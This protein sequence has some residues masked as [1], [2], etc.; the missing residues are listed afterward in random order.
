MPIHG[1]PGGVITANPTEPSQTSASGVWTTEQQLINQSAGR[2][3]PPYYLI[4]RSLRF[5]FADSTYLNRTPGS[6]GNLRIWTLS[7]WVKLCQQTNDDGIIFSAGTG[8]SARSQCY[9]ALSTGRLYFTSFVSA[10]AYGAFTNAQ[11]R[12]PSAWYHVV[13]SV[14]TTQTTAANRVIFY[15][16]GVAQSMNTS[17]GGG[18]IPQNSDTYVNAANGHC[19]G[20]NPPYSVGGYPTIYLTEQYLIDGQALTPSSFGLNDPETGVW[21]PKRYTGTYGTNGF[22]LNFSDNSGTT[23]TTLGKDS[24]GNGNNWTPN[25]FSVTAGA[26]NDSMVDSPTAY[27]TDTGVGGEVRGNYATVSP[28]GYRTTTPTP[29]ISNGNLDVVCPSGSLSSIGTSTFGVSSGKWYWEVT[30][31][32]TAYGNTGIVLTPF[33]MAASSSLDLGGLSNEYVYVNSGSKFNNNSSSSYGASW[34]NGDVIGVALDLDAGT[35]VFYKNGSSQGTAFSSLPSGIYLV[36]GYDSFNGS[37]F[38]FNFGQRAFAYTAPSGFKALCTQ[39]LPTPTIGA[40]S[41]TQANDYFNVVLWTGNGST[42]NITGVGFQP[43]FVWA[44]KRSGAESHGLYD[45]VRGASNRLVSNTTAAAVTDAGVS[46]FLSDGFSISGAD[47][48]VTNDNGSTYVGWN[49]KANGAGSSNTAGTITSTVSANTTSGFSI[50]TYTGN[51]TAGATVGHGLGVAP[52]MVIVK[53]RSYSPSAWRMYNSNLANAATTLDLNSTAAADG[54]NGTS[55]NSTAPT[56]TV[57]SLGTADNTNRSGATYVAYCFA[58]V[59]GYSA[60]GIYSGTGSAPGAFTY[61][62]FKP[63]FVLIKESNG[64]DGWGMYDDARDPNN[65]VSYLL[66]AQDS[67]AESSASANKIDFLSNGFRV[68]TDGTQGNFINESGKTYIYAA[69]AETPFKYSLAR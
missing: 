1:Y 41:T 3:P 23:S 18:A 37:G 67:G 20:S 45:A 19:I 68:C 26:G 38:V 61:L 29:T 9:W 31:T 48:G 5:N 69:F 64:V 54:T 8:A 33:N 10:S 55:F 40:T 39:N 12:D 7:F 51:G 28:I 11:F 52:S 50:V 43:D 17:Y 56:S 47:S 4:S 66:Q 21:S 32:G 35:L 60:F 44:K 36:G 57:F 46:A 13:L 22:Y 15:I 30:K 49:W 53:S 25:N 62:G 42:Q 6:A 63:A 24:S 58:P 2:W 59:A 16:N 14:D 27:G 65:V 34:T